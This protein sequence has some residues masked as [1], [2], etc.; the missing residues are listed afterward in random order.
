MST[1][2]DL[3]IDEAAD[4][5]SG[6]LSPAP[7]AELEAPSAAPAPAQEAS[8]APAEGEPQPESDDKPPPGYVPHAA[9]H[10]ERARVK[11]MAAEKAAYEARMNARL[12]ALQAMVAGKPVEPA[13]ADA[14]EEDPVALL[15]EVKTNLSEM[16]RQQQAQ[17]EAAQLTAYVERDMQ[18]FVAVKPDLGDAAGYLMESRAQELRLM[19][20]GEDEIAQDINAWDIELTRNAARAGQSVAAT[21]YQ[22]AEM[23]GYRAA[24]ASALAVAPAQAAAPTAAARVAAIAN[25]QATERSLSAAAGSPPAGDID[26]KAILALPDDEFWKFAGDESKF[27]KLAGA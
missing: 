17:G 11:Q 22:L 26:L 4:D 3:G 1:L 7:V 6:D 5:L 21:I 23:R 16:Q 2:N 13:P 9:L 25:G 8:A 20:Y 27:R 14:D 24:A 18:Q 19:G 15:R 10:A 12:E